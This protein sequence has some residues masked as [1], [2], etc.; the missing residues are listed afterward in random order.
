M[1]SW[2]KALIAVACCVVIAWGGYFTLTKWQEYR[3][4]QAYRDALTVMD[5]EL[6]RVLRADPHDDEKV[7]SMCKTVRGHPELNSEDLNERILTM[8]RMLNYL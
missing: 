5:A 8:C 7:R 6:H 1:D 3:S 2:L 4:E